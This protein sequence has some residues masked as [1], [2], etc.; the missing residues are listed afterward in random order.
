[1]DPSTARWKRLSGNTQNQCKTPYCEHGWPQMRSVRCTPEDH[2]SVRPQRSSSARS[3]RG[4]EKLGIKM[5]GTRLDGVGVSK[6]CSGLRWHEAGFD[7]RGWQHEVASRV[8]E[9]FPCEVVHRIAIN[10]ASH[11]EIPEW[12][13]CPCCV[14]GNPNFELH[15]NRVFTRPGV[16]ATPA[17]TFL[18]F[19]ANSVQSTFLAT[20]VQL[21]RFSDEG[22]P[23]K[24]CCGAHL[25]GSGR[26]RDH[27]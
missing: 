27:A 4:S 22:V 17:S 23:V 5:S 14:L 15:S 8:G 1:M 21:A 3:R 19:F 20:T 25:Q 10:S 6:C 9:K 18:H 24:K 11:A 26:S 13:R 16:V 12:S 7:R 2:R